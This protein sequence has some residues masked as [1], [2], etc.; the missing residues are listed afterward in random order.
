[1]Q[2]AFY[3]VAAFILCSCEILMPDWGVEGMPCSSNDDCEFDLIC[4]GN[5]TCGKEIMLDWVLIPG[6][7]FMMGSDTSESDE[8]PVHLVN[9][10][11]FQMTKTEVTVSEY[12][13]CVQAAGCTGPTCMAARS[14][15]PSPPA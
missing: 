5:G 6:G 8:L 4:M 15:A 10:P 11:E 9:V 2:R 7:S 14:A 12:D 1:M 13:L 3:L